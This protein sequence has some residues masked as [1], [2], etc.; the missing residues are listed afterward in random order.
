MASAALKRPLPGPIWHWSPEIASLWPACDPWPVP[1]WL[2]AGLARIVKRGTQRTVLRVDLPGLSFYLKQHHLPDRLTWFRQCLRA[3]KGRREF[4]RLLELARRGVPAPEPLGWGRRPG[5]GGVGE[6][7]IVTRAID[8]VTP[9]HDMLAEGLAA[10]QRQA[11]ANALGRFLAKLHAAG[12]DHRDLHLGN[13]VVRQTDGEYELFLVDLDAVNL[14]PPLDRRRSLTNLA[15]FGCGCVMFTRRADRLRFLR[16]YV[17]ERGWLDLDRDRVQGREFFDIARAIEPKAW[18][19]CL[20]FWARRDQRCLVTNRYFRAVNVGSYA[21]MAVRGVDDDWLTR[22]CG[23]PDALFREPGVR[24]LKHSAS[25]TVAEIVAFVDGEPRPAILKK[26]AAT[27]WSDSWAAL[28]RPTPVLRS[29][30]NGQGFVERNLPT[31]RPLVMLHQRRHGLLHEGY[32]V[33]EKLDG[34]QGLDAYVAGLSHLPG[35]EG[36]RRLR[37][38]IE[39]VARA[40]RDMHHR[41]ISHRDL[42][43]ANLLVTSIEIEET[44]AGAACP[45]GMSPFSVALTNLWFIDLVG[46]SR[47]SRLGSRRRVQNIA[48]L[49]ASFLGSP[50]VTRTDRLR[51]LSIYLG[52]HVY[53]KGDW[54]A[55]WRAIDHATAAKVSRNQKSGRPLG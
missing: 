38:Q 44:P 22:F 12:V 37:R 40:V 7:F 5:W 29:W 34:V 6:S 11:L 16:R 8:G 27:R 31:P 20:A 19:N 17:A 26:I 15:L 54:K 2:A 24:I 55:W 50:N 39:R 43:A 28:V 48:R 23:D 42:K 3:P 36:R 10:N 46:V 25:S 18:A 52:W 1:A 21:G 30:I 45:I 41:Q 53:G 35:A 47:H 33:T 49:S 51:F 14:G 32:L 13:I 4:D 9:L